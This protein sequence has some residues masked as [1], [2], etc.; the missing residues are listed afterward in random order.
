MLPP[1]LQEELVN[2]MH[3]ERLEA[4]QRRHELMYA[5][6]ARRRL[7]LRPL[8]ATIGGQMVALGEYLQG[9][10]SD[11]ALTTSENPT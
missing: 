9:E 11:T 4:F 1:L 10:D 2:I 3:R 6:T 8:L 7:N 5:K